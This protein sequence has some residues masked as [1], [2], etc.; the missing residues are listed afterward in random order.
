MDFSIDATDLGVAVLQELWNKVTFG[1]ALIVTET[2]DV[3]FENESFIEFSKCISAMN[4]LFQALHA[5]RIEA[6][7]GLAPTRKALETLDSLLK[8]AHNIIRDYKSWSRLRLLLNSQSML[9]Q[10]QNL[11][12]EIAETISSLG[13]ANFDMTLNLKVQVNQI[14]NDLRSMEF[15]SAAATESIAS[16]IQKS[17]AQNERNRD[18]A[19]HLLH[20]IADAVGTSANASLVQ[21]E[22]AL[23]KQEKEELE[24]QKKQAEALQLSQLIRLLYSTEMVRSPKEEET[25][26]YQQYQFDSFTCPLCKDI[27]TDPVAILCGHSFERQ[28]IQEYFRI[29]ETT[30]PTCRLHLPSQELT[31]NLS[32]RNSILEWKK[33]DMDLKFQNTVHSIASDD[34]DT[35]NKALQDM[36]VLMEMPCYRDEVVEKGLI[37]RMVE[38]LKIDR[39]NTKAVLKC[40]Y[41]LSIHSEDNK[42]TIVKAGAIRRI[43]KQFYKGEAEPD[44][45]AILLELSAKETL[46]EQIGNTKDCIPLLVSLLHNNNPEIPQKVQN[47]LQNLSSNTNFVI[48][49]AEAG[50]FQPFVECF[51]QGLSET[52]ASMAA[53]LINMQL[54]ENSMK[55]LEDKQF[56]HKLVEMLSSSSPARKYACQCIKKL[57]D[58]PKMSKQFLADTI[59]IPCLLGLI[60]FS[61][62]DLHWKQEATEI[63]TLLIGSSQVPDFQKYPCLQELQSEYNVSLFLQ[64]AAA[65]NCQTKLQFL[66]FLVVLSNKSETTRDL[67]RSDKKAVTDLFS[68]L[69]CSQSDV[70]QE[71]MKL[72]YCISK[73]HPTGVPLPPSPEKE[74]AITTLVAILTSSTKVQER[75]SAAGIIGLLPTDDIIV[76]EILCKSEALKAIQEVISTAE[77]EHCRTKEPVEPG[78]SLLENALAALLRYTEPSKP[79]LQRQV[80]QLE[81][82]PLLVQLLSRGSSV[83]KQRT[84]IALAH[85]SQANNLLTIN[86]PTIAKQATKS[87]PMLRVTSLFPN[88][89]W[90]CSASTPKH[91]LCSVHGSTCSSRYTFCLVKADALRPLVQIL[92]DTHSG[93]AEAALMALETLLMDQST[94]PHAAAAIVDSEGLVAILEVLEK[95]SLSAKDKALVLFQKILEHRE[96]TH[97][98][99]QR[100]ETILVHLLS[101]NKLKKKAALVLRQMNIIPDQSSYF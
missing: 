73:D 9:S 28:A 72:I 101:D 62:S 43:V 40:L 53:A 22:L 83:T 44:A 94:L 24:V 37:P 79:R 27:M 16:E 45:V 29:G 21:N 48:K 38:L 7:T 74:A 68:S 1:A 59:T 23:L 5:K 99:S 3:A 63:L 10:M 35:L 20:K 77:D 57:L 8:K 34:H 18:H 58:V 85:L 36:Q 65:S 61:K 26:T 97:S 100:S 95:G 90:C 67:I 92:T 86:T 49:M 14:I 50:H 19:I 70:R 25:T 32:L 56:I 11:A 93:A 71:T 39:L 4:I 66:Q 12:R 88:M 6:I 96:I 55:N 30:C 64:L 51:K 15:R 47:V 91:N 84:A 42:A 69:N 82:Y 52:R 81:L 54:D 41:Y 60:S 98:V 46:V 75:S 2:K 13:L 78:E 17:I 87:M 31:P 33:R 80:G 76:D 89:F